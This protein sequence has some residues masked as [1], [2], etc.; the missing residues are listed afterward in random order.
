VQQAV[1]DALQEWAD[2]AA[3]PRFRIQEPHLGW[4][5]A[6]VEAVEPAEGWNR[7]LRAAFAQKDEASY[8]RALEQLAADAEVQPWPARALTRL[9]QGLEDVGAKVR[10][11]QVLRK[12]QQ[13]HPADFWVNHNLAMALQ[14]ANP[15]EKEEEVRFKTAAVA[16]R[17]GSPGAH[18]NLGQALHRQDRVEEAI[19]CFRK[20]LA[21]E[22]KYFVAH[23]YLGY[24]LQENGRVEEA[25][26]CYRQALALNP[27]HAMTH[28]NLG[29]AL[30]GKGKVDEGIACLRRAIE[31]DPAYAGAHSNLGSALKDR[32]QLDEALACHRKALAL[33]PTV[34]EFHSNLGLVLAAK[35]QL[36]QAISSYRRALELDPR[37][38]PAHNNLGNALKEKGR[39]DE[40]LACFRKAVELKPKNAGVHYNLGKALKAKGRV[41]EAIAC[42]REAIKLNPRLADAHL[43]LG[44]ALR[45]KGKVD[46]AIACWRKALALDPKLASVHYN[47]G[48]AL[49]ATGR[50]NEAIACWRKAL[51]LDPRDASTHGVL[52]QALLHRGRYAEGRDASARTVALLPDK[53]P[54]RPLALQQVQ[55]CERLLKLQERLPRFLR[56]EEQPAS[57]AESLDLAIM[58][59]LKRM[60]VATVTF[61]AGAFSA[62]PKLAADLQTGQRYN[63]ACD[64]ALATAGQG[65]DRPRGASEQWALRRRALT[66]LRA[67]LAAWTRHL[68]TGPPATRAAIEQQMRHWQKDPDLAAFRDPAELAKLP[69]EE[70]AAFAQL[71]ADVTALLK[72]AATP[73]ARE[74]RP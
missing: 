61:A 15:Q 40:A 42:F 68:E 30:R 57:A 23:V 46:E 73:A 25:I 27:N 41:E 32:G 53:H 52:G 18:F 45:N 24:V 17:P 65:K 12:A 26:A 55:T 54:L 74:K 39:P 49:R 10:A 13:S 8:R 5:R 48:L 1:S 47:L 20:A 63:A 71:W 70:R 51:A 4:L 6:V 2:L 66:W 69:A 19:A 29:N 9:A 56:G 37:Y 3:N 62:D 34:A 28:N 31:L 35:G 16:L 60:H 22:P 43:N 11:V 59:R 33:D 58:C 38:A 64:A 67:D 7:K 72:K 21:L 36:D 50:T 44:N 14:G